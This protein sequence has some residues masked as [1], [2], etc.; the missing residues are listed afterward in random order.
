MITSDLCWQNANMKFA[1]IQTFLP[2]RTFLIQ[3]SEPF[4]DTFLGEAV[5]TDPFVHS[6]SVPRFTREHAITL[7]TF[8]TEGTGER[9]IYLV[10]FSVFSPEAAELLLKSLEEPDLDTTI[11]LVTPYPYTVPATI[12]SRVRLI[13]SQTHNPKQQFIIS[14]R[15]ALLT[16]IKEE[17]GSDADDSAATRRASAVELLDALEAHV[18]NDP[19]K[20]QTIFDAKKMLLKANMPTKFVLEY[21]VSVVL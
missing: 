18:K 20:A 6:L 9:R 19:Q 14:T 15:D 8:I 3:G 7:A 16:Q 1:D 2:E 21:A 13:H 12:R 5:A 10:F 4:F 11:V 17:F